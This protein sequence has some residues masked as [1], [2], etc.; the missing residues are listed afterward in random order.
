MPEMLMMLSIGV[1]VANIALA[2]G[3]LVI[4]G[5]IYAGTKARFTL[6]LLAFAVAFLAQNALVVYSYVTMMPI[7]PAA[8]N[9]YLFL[10][11]AFQAVGLGAILWS[12]TR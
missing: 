11:G 10:I 2:L 3:L 12:A 1:G 7:V 4:Y 8:M 5:G 6:A 9:P